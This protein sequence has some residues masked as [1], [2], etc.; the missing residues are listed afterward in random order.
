MEKYTKSRKRFIKS[1]NSIQYLFDYYELNDNYS[2]N[3]IKNSE[4]SRN[5]NN[6]IKGYQFLVMKLSY[7]MKMEVSRELGEGYQIN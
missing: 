4:N 1:E 5:I 7:I 6:I 3:K 2:F